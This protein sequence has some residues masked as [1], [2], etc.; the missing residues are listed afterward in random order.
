MSEGFVRPGPFDDL[1][2]GMLHVIEI[3]PLGMRYQSKVTASEFG[4]RTPLNPSV[5]LRGCLQVLKTLSV[6]DMLDVGL[7]WNTH[8]RGCR[9]YQF[10]LLLSP[11]KIDARFRYLLIR[12]RDHCLYLGRSSWLHHIL[13]SW[14]QFLPIELPSWHKIILS[15]CQS[16]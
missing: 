4:S 16:S 12:R 15:I 11:S 9:L 13:T 7:I 1:V 5:N 10:E 3:S 14:F 6:D 2:V 8:E